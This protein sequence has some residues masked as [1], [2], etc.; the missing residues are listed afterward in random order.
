MNSRNNK[1]EQIGWSEISHEEFINYSLS[2]IK[3][4]WIGKVHW[5]LNEIVRI[6]RSGNIQCR[7][8]SLTS[9]SVWKD[10]SECC[11]VPHYNLDEWIKGVYRLKEFALLHT[12]LEDDTFNHLNDTANLAI[13]KGYHP[14]IKKRVIVDGVHRA[15]AVEIE[16]KKSKAI[17]SI[18]ILECY[19]ELIHTIFPFEFSHLLTHYTEL[20]E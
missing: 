6:F 11:F 7:K 15:T 13:V 18:K 12:T 16:S 3:V 1:V 20:N 8:G 17:P 9:F 14:I 4:P 19:G 5:E 2:E 10:L